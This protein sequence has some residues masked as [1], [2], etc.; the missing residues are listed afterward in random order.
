MI[1][2]GKY[3]TYKIVWE[4]RDFFNQHWV[5][6]VIYRKQRRWYGLMRW[7]KVWIDTK[8]E[9]LREEVKYLERYQI[10]D[11]I[12]LAIKSYEKFVEQFGDVDAR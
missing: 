8:R 3:D 7:T 4:P 6:P 5:C 9:V 2:N 12:K 11:Y 1:V 10:D